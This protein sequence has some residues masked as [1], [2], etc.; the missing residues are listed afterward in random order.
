MIVVTGATGHIG[1]VLVR[2]LLKNGKKVRVLVRPGSTTIPIDDLDVEIVRGDIRDKE[3][4]KKAFQGAEKVF[5]LAAIISILPGANKEL[6]DTNVNGTKNVC[7]VCLEQ[8]IKLIYTSSVHAISNRPH[9]EPL[10][11]DTPVCEK[12]AL[13]KYGQTKALATNYLLDAVKNKGLNAVIVHPAG[14]MGPYDYMPSQMGLVINAM[15]TWLCMGVK[16]AY[17]FVDV[18]DVVQGILLADQKG[19]IG[20]RYI[21]SGHILSVGDQ[22]KM[23][24]KVLGRKHFFVNMPKILAYFG[25]YIMIPFYSLLKLE[26]ILTPES[27]AILFSNA[28]LRHDKAKTKLGYTVRPFE[29]TIQDTIEWIH[30][31]RY[32]WKKT[33][34]NI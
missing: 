26:P 6:Y 2:E 21:L 18:R 9:G 10:T 15:T 31:N 5:H 16:G 23:V 28:D 4:L 20:E 14:V 34:H 12:T 11:E 17:N 1:N 8:G 22:K 7:D 27:L 29:E 13:G 19:T 30:Q 25:A 24:D 32:L 3:S 33:Q